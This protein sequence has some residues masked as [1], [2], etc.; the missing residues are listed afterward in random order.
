[1]GGPSGKGKKS[2][3]NAQGHMT[4]MAAST[5]TI[6]GKKKSSTPEPTDKE[7]GQIIHAC[8]NIWAKGVIS[9]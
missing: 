3:I 1:M 7:H 6:Y 4:K 2:H 8:D 5:Y 9:P